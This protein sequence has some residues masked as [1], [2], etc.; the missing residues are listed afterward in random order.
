[1]R[2]TKKL[3]SSLELTRSIAGKS[4]STLTVA[5]WRDWRKGSGVLQSMPDWEQDYA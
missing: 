3:C 2:E 4:M 1:M 5:E